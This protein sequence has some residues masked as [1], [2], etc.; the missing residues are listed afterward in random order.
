MAKGM[1]ALLLGLKAKQKAGEEEA[2][3]EEEM[4]EDESAMDEGILVAAEEVMGAI[5]SKDAEALASAL[6]SFIEQC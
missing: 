3:P 5:Q 1:T 6:K 4:P 2:A